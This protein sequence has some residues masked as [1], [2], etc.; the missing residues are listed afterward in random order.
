M[1]VNSME[2]EMCLMHNCT[3][4]TILR[5][6]KYF[7]TLTKSTG[8]ILTITGCDTCIVGSEK[9]T[10]IL[11]MGTQITI[12]NIFFVSRFYSYPTKL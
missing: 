11:P 8:D 3:T 2:E 12:E 6:T 5:E 9:A 4:N 1:H 7:K 10:I